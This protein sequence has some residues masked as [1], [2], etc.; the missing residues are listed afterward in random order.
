MSQREKKTVRDPEGWKGNVEGRGR[1]FKEMKL[2]AAISD[3]KRMFGDTLRARA[4][5]SVAD[6]IGW[7]VIVYNLFKKVRWSL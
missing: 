2:E 3:L 5:E 7:F 6:M 1:V 4:R